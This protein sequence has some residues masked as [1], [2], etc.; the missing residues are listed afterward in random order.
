M[1]PIQEISAHQAVATTA[2]DIHAAAACDRD[3]NPIAIGIEEPFQ[4]L[5][6]ARVLVQLIEQCHRRASR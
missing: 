5:L 3:S 6:P 2:I 1:H 4:E